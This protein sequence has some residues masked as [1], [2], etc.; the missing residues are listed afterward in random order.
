MA[1]SDGSSHVPSTARERAA[2][3]AADQALQIDRR[4]YKYLIDRAT[5]DAVRAAVAPFCKSDPNAA[6]SPTKTYT[7]DTLYFD[8]PRLA[9]FWANDNEQAD[10]VKVRVRSYAD[11][12]ASPRFFEVKRR[13]NDV[14]SKSRGRVDRALCQTLLCDP[15]SRI[16]PSITGKDRAA[17]ERFL[18]ISRTS[19]MR[20]FTMVRYRREPYVSQIDDYARVTFDTRISAVQLDR[21]AFDIP[22]NSWR[23]L[24]DAVTEHSV[25][26]LV[27]LEL[28]FTNQVPLWMVDMTRR[29]GLVRRA[30]SKFGT[31]IRAFHEPFEPRVPRMG[32]W[33]R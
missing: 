12:P 18:A 25:D 27:V 9:L 1:L 13:I 29:L 30:F 5:M 10:R 22:G 2:A 23:A 21:V 26:S 7:I 24:D 19:H 17:V 14:I 15:A 28:K 16:P 33:S 11:A 3:S 20:P 8:T 31:S 32:R 4:E 6:N